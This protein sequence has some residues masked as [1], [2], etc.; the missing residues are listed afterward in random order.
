M[1]SVQ[2][3]LRSAQ[4]R[5]PTQCEMAACLSSVWA[6]VTFQYILILVKTKRRCNKNSC[7]GQEMQFI[8]V[9]TYLEAQLNVPLPRPAPRTRGG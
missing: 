4:Q 8:E 6:E 3:I 9:I 5:I 7:N 2:V 1:T